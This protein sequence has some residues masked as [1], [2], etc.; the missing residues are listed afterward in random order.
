[1]RPICSGSRGQQRA[2][3]LALA[4][5]VLLS[6]QLVSLSQA[7]LFSR[8]RPEADEFGSDREDGF[9]IDITR[10]GNWGGSRSPK[11]FPRILGIP[12]RSG[13]QGSSRRQSELMRL[14]KQKLVD[15]MLNLENLGRCIHEALENFIKENYKFPMICCKL[16][17]VDKFCENNPKKVRARIDVDREFRI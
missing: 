3:L 6:A 15:R 17:I 2:L 16:P 1:M 5:L 8:S 10:V 14:D 13:G 11:R 4:A 9:E 7:I 12:Y